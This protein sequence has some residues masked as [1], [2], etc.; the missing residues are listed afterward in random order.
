[1]L[2]DLDIN[3][4]NPG[5]DFRNHEETIGVDFTNHLETIGE[6]FRNHLET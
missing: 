6:Y 3:F 4:R 5:V 2:R 1:M